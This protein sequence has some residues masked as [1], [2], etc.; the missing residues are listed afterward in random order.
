MVDVWFFF[1]VTIVGGIWYRIISQMIQIPFGLY[2]TENQSFVY[3]IDTL[4]CELR[5]SHAGHQGGTRVLAMF[6]SAC[7]CPPVS[8]QLWSENKDHAGLPPWCCRQHIWQI[9]T[10]KKLN[11]NQGALC[12]VIMGVRGLVRLS[13][14]SDLQMF[15]SGRLERLMLN[16]GE[17]HPVEKWYRVAGLKSVG[18][19][20]P[21][22]CS[23]KLLRS[24]CPPQ[25]KRTQQAVMENADHTTHWPLDCHV[26]VQWPCGGFQSPRSSHCAGWPTLI[27]ESKLHLW[28]WPFSGNFRHHLCDWALPRQT[29]CIWVHHLVWVPAESE[30]YRHKTSV[31]YAKSCVQWWL[32]VH[33]WDIVLCYRFWPHISMVK[34]HFK[35]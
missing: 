33:F 2:D 24:L 19:Q 5:L 1:K 23:C 31:F 26:C 35:N 18:R 17:R 8:M 27:H 16:E 6:I 7:L 14:S 29:P 28:T 9:P 3:T 20:I 32:V 34:N 25:R 4:Q 12:L 30:P 13:Q 22:T 10:G 15:H 21:P 11:Q